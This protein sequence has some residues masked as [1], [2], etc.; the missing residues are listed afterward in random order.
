MVAAVA[1]DGRSIPVV[2]RRCPNEDWQMG[3]VDLITEMLRLVRDAMDALDNDR[4][5]IVIADRGIGNRRDARAPGG[6]NF[7]IPAF[8]GMTGGKW[9]RRRRNRAA[10]LRFSAP[11]AL[12]A[13]NFARERDMSAQ[14]D[15]AE[16]LVA[17][18]ALGYVERYVVYHL[19]E[20]RLFAFENVVYAPLHR[21][22]A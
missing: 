9:K 12:F 5:A 13:S 15:H 7:W 22:G 2:W 21:V 14:P 1:F 10:N 11:S 3:L 16:Q 19:V 20:Q 6:A 4:K 18:Q 8:A 17:R